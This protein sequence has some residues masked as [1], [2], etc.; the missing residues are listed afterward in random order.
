MI[1]LVEV[2]VVW[3]GPYVLECREV[4]ETEW[5]VVPLSLQVTLGDISH[6]LVEVIEV[7][8]DLVV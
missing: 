3:V 7:S 2:G 8:H 1:Q 5:C 4:T 6:K